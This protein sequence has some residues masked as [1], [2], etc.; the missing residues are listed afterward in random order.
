MRIGNL[1]LAVLG[2]ILASGASI[3]NKI[4]NA[5]SRGQATDLSVPKTLA[6]S[7]TRQVGSAGGYFKASPGSFAAARRAKAKRKGIAM[8]KA[9]VRG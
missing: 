6:P 2:A 7:K 3:I 1:N 8:H 9:R 4:T 5:F